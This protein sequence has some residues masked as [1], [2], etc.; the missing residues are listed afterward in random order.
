ML[1]PRP[2]AGACAACVLVAAIVAGAPARAQEPQTLDPV[3]QEAQQLF[4]QGRDAVKRGELVLAAEKF[5]RSQM[6]HATPGTLL[7]LA[8]VEEQLGKL[9]KAL[10]HFEAAL[11][12]LAESDERYPIAS[13][14]ANRIRARIPLLRIDRAAG[15]PADMTIRLG[16]TALAASTLGAYEQMDPGPYIVTTSASGH[17]DRRYEIKL[18]EGARTTL[19][20]E[21]GKEVPKAPPPGPPSS[22]PTAVQAA[23]IAVGGVGIAGLGIGAVTGI[24]AIVKKG[25]AASACPN[26]MMCSGAG[27]QT[28]ATGQTLASVSTASFVVGIA[29]V[30]VGVTLLVAGREKPAAVD[31]GSAAKPAGPSASFAPW[32][33]PGGAGLGAQGRF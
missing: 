30:A 26:P 23:G 11:K 12:G 3:S 19:A 17:E 9:V 29:G 20:V 31:G 8:N 24:L 10:V 28:A 2:R 21:A 16:G 14:G 4:L 15:A 13:E 32:V 33:L 27:L 22:R 6:L 1:I 25:D 18:A 5:E 7:N